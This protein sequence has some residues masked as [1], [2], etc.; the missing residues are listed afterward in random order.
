VAAELALAGVRAQVVDR[1]DDLDPTI[2]AGSINVATAEVLHRRGLLPAARQAHAA[3]VEQMAVF[4]K[5]VNRAAASGGAFGRQLDRH[6]GHDS[7]RGFPVTGH[8]A[9]MMFR[10]QLVNSSDP[11]L[12]SHTAVDGATLLT[13]HQVE[14]LLRDHAGR[15]GV[16][17]R[18]GVEVTGVEQGDQMVILHTKAGPMTSRWVV[19]ADGGRSTLRKLLGIGFSGTDP[20]I[21]GYQAI[22][23]MDGAEQLQPGWTWTRNGV[24]SYGPVPGRILTVQFTAA[25]AD[26]TAPVTAEEVQASVRLVSGLP[27]TVT[28]LH[29][30]A[31]R[32]TDNARQADTYRL[33]RVLLAGDA[34]HVHS[35]FSGQGLNLGVGDAINVGWKL[36]ATVNGWAPDGLLDS[37][38]TERTPIAAWVLDWTRAQVALMRGESKTAQLRRV[39][40]H[41]L[42]GTH[43]GMTRV[44]ALAS[45][46]AQRYA[47]RPG[48]PA[49]VDYDRTGPLDVGRLLGDVELA[50]ATLLAD[51]CHDGRFVL[52]D[53]SPGHRY[54]TACAPWLDRVLV[55]KDDS[56]GPSALIR[57]DGVIAW[58]GPRAA[59]PGPDDPQEAGALPAAQDDTPAAPPDDAAGL[60]RTLQRWAGTASLLPG[61]PVPTW[62]G[63]TPVSLD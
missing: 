54:A 22:A 20:E 60:R 26:R 28:K 38:S 1:L 21:T 34:A 15:L 50:D 14:Q 9:G 59:I 30:R 2:K 62:T 18:R 37:Y 41:Q 63:L 51:H 40:E 32:W 24:Y 56:A 29:G 39:V 55:V 19:A 10:P 11:G 44:V 6:S 58:S 31:T 46:I 7:G 17:F 43:D 45:G 49:G 36:A 23:D 52:L 12:A 5:T 35:P 27:I 8:F 57:P 3:T 42:L 47:L 53:R 48:D 13:Q 61:T 33:G 16:T 4:A 25:P